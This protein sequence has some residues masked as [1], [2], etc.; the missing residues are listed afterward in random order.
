M[1]T[2]RWQWFSQL[3]GISTTQASHIE[4]DDSWVV[5]PEQ[6]DDPDAYQSPGYS[7]FHEIDKQ[8]T[9]AFEVTFKSLNYNIYLASEQINLE[10]DDSIISFI[11]D[12][13]EHCLSSSI[14]NK[15]EPKLDLFAKIEKIFYPE[16]FNAS[17]LSDKRFN[18]IAFIL[19]FLTKDPSVILGYRELKL[20][21]INV[22]MKLCKD[23]QKDFDKL[24]IA[25]S[26]LYDEGRKSAHTFTLKS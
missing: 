14:L 11:S 12:L 25:A 16:D 23:L 26:F 22:F 19:V 13:Y 17:E 2:P 3:A 21:I 4:R 10:S 5:L 18:H 6:D 8:D 7:I 1:F 9:Q 20:A 24:I 15:Q